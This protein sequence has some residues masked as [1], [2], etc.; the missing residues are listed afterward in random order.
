M[1]LHGN[2]SCAMCVG[3]QFVQEQLHAGVELW[4]QALEV[5]AGSKCNALVAWW[6]VLCYNLLSKAGSYSFLRGL[7]VS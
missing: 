6:L 2:L 5:A 4:A 7:Q 1:L 3:S